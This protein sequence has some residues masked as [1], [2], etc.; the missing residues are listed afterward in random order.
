MES[1]TGNMI[2]AVVALVIA[3]ILVGNVVI[4]TV[5]GVNTTGYTSAELALWGIITLAAIIGVFV[6]AFRAFGIL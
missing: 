5:K 3:V 2:G 1:F 4:P 6:F